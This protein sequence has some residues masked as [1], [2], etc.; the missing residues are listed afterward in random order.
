MKQESGSVAGSQQSVDKNHTHSTYALE[1][2][3]MGMSGTS[4]VSLSEF[5]E[6]SQV[7]DENQSQRQKKRKKRKKKKTSEEDLVI[8][9]LQETPTEIILFM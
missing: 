8:F 6:G 9:S 1:E 3:S 7:G 5:S 4:G 2:S